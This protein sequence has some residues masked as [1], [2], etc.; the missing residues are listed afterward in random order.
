MA[1][2]RARGGAERS[3]LWG[4]GGPATLPGAR[5]RRFMV[6][7]APV[8][9]SFLSAQEI[10]SLSPP[11]LLSPGG[12][13][14]A[15]KGTGLELQRPAPGAGSPI[16]GKLTAPPRRCPWHGGARRSPAPSPSLL[17]QRR[18]AAPDPADCPQTARKAPETLGSADGTGSA[19][20]DRT[21]AWHLGK[22][23]NPL[24]SLGS[25]SVFFG[26]F[27]C[28]RPSHFLNPPLP[29]SKTRNNTMVPF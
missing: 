29:R 11:G 10:L 16:H 23:A 18:A 6:L 24:R 26:R 1:G 25:A 13:P 14:D 7:A 17:F 27:G 2:G 8:P 19:G 9:S 21:H 28:T 12:P 3:A 15:G 22:T 20:G 5:P 4:L